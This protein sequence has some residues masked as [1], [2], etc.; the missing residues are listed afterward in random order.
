MPVY[1]FHQQII[2]FAIILLNGKV[3]PWIHMIANFAIA[4]TGALIISIILMKWKITRFLLGE[5]SK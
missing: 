2:Y 4:V 1:L 3:N 5:S